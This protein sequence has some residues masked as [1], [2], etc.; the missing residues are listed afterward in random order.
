[1]NIT[2]FQVAEFLKL[3]EEEEHANDSPFQMIIISNKPINLGS[4]LASEWEGKE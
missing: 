2:Q 4:K 3:Q 1:V